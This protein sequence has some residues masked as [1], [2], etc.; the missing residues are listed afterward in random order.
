M[1]L[2]NAFENLGLDS[3]LQAI[4]D[5]LPATL[6]GSGGVKVDVG[7]ST[8]PAGAATSAKQSDGS[9]KTQVVDGSGNVIGSTG[10]ALD[11]NIKSGATALA[12]ESGGN[13]AT[14]ATNTA[15]PTPL[16]ATISASS[17]GAT[18]VVA[19]VSGKRI[20]VMQVVLIVNA[21]VNVKF[22]SHV[23]PTDITGLFYLAA[24]AGFS[25]GY[26]HIGQFQTVSGEALDI[27][28]SGSVAVGGYIT[29]VTV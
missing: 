29:Y 10:N 28:L 27:N 6:G 8:L 22:Q 11:I 19:A 17:T 18:T 1:A 12:L 4:R 20:R 14:I 25:S 16:F 23:T 24:N 2:R 3:T 7:S 21:P 9:Q 15:A 5:R 26:S 13:L